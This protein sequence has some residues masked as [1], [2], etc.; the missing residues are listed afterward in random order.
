L[1][2]PVYMTSAIEALDGKYVFVETP[3]LRLDEY[4]DKRGEEYL[5]GSVRLVEVT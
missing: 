4:V 5:M 1:S 3:S 2:V